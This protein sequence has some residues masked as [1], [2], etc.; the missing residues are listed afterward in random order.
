MLGENNKSNMVFG[1]FVRLCVDA[2]TPQAYLNVFEAIAIKYR[3]FCYFRRFQWA[4]MH[5]VE[6]INAKL[7]EL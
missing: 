3:K 2:R 5:K 1:W 6:K 4:K 7:E